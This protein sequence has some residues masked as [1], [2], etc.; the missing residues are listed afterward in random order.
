MEVEKQAFGYDKE[1]KLRAD[2]LNDKTAEPILSLLA[3]NKNEAIGHIL[4]TRVYIAEMIS[5]PLLHILAPLAIIP[6]YQKMGI[7][8][9]LIREGLKGLTKMGSKMVFVLGHME[10]YPKFG[11]V[12]DAKKKGYSAPFPIPEEFANAWMV[13]SLDPQ[14]TQCRPGTIICANELNKPEHW[15]E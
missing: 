5:Q 12:P 1:A 13:Q 3:F 7:G 10:Y 4:F 14:G 6:E 2:L 8:G 9:L 15:R 11:F